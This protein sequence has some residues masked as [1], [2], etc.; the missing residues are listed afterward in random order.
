MRTHT[1]IR[2]LTE[3]ESTVTEMKT[4][5]HLKHSEYSYPSY[6]SLHKECQSLKPLPDFRLG[7][8][9]NDMQQTGWLRNQALIPGREKRIFSPLKPTKPSSVE[10]KM[11]GSIPLLPHAFSWQVVFN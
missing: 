2:G 9:C 7:L 6:V 1:K 5:V 3:G 10:V 11:Y 8:L 4:A